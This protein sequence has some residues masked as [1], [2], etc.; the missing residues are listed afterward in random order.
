MLRWMRDATTLLADRIFDGFELLR[1]PRLVEIERG[2][3]AR[4]RPFSSDEPPP[5]GTLDTR[6]GTLLP[7]LIDAHCHLA[8]VGLFEPHEAPSPAAVAHNLRS[9]LEAGV[10]TAGDMGCTIPL[11]RSLRARTS[12]A[13]ES[14]PAIRAAGPLLTAPLGYPLDWMSGAHVWL[15]AAVPVTDQ[16]S[17]RRAVQRLADAGMDH[18]KLC[19]MHRGYDL[20]PLPVFSKKVARAIVEEAHALGM[21]ALAH[22]HWNADYRVALAAGVDALMHSAFDPLDDETVKRVRDAGVG[23]CPTLWVFHSACLGAEA[24]FDR[25][26]R[27]LA[28]AVG[29]VR[30]SWRRF[31]DAYAASGEVMPAGIAGG[32]P[33]TAA[34]LGVKN[35]MANL[36]LLREAGVPL[37]YGSDGPYGFSEVGHP[38]D[39]LRTLA[40]AGLSASECLRAATSGAATV[41]GARDI[42]RIAPGARAD[43][44]W[45]DGDPSADLG[46][47]DRVRGVFRGGRRVGSARPGVVR[48]AAWRGLLATLRHAAVIQR[49]R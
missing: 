11:I 15:G 28:R 49:S 12:D 40:D 18:V 44:V 32:L 29:P 27:R 21:R 39:E 5:P 46:A 47:L 8:R 31:A 7:G 9:A 1:G 23:V 41:L 30:R 45:V 4:V 14:G 35:A 26:P 34:R 19:I 43:L 38:L 10:T 48:A 20:D 25:D 42:G 13:L 2:L 17:A 36:L 24:R 22:A 6:G 33:K 16:R 37:A 3:V